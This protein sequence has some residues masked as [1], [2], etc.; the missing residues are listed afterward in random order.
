MESLIMIIIL[1]SLLVASIIVNITYHMKYTVLKSTE[2][3]LNF[4]EALRDKIDIVFNSMSEEEY[5]KMFKELQRATMAK[6]NNKG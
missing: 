4:L 3:D 1:S 2:Y 5:Q 6:K